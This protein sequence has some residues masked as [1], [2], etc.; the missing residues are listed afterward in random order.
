MNEK[1]KLVRNCVILSLEAAQKMI[2]A[3]PGASAALKEAGKTLAKV[4]AQLSNK[5]PGC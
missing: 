3:L 1:E 4:V 5:G 2:K